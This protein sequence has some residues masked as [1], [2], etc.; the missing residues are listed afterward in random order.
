MLSKLAQNC[1][2]SHIEWS[3]GL[4]SNTEGQVI[5]GEGEG[6][7]EEWEGEG[8]QGERGRGRGRGWLMWSYTRC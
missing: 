2:I 1:M 5:K 3:R 6:E 7:E 8:E 4:L